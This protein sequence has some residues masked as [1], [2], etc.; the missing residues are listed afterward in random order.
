MPTPP[1]TPSRS[2][3]P[4]LN[5]FG[6]ASGFVE[7]RS[8][9]VALD[10]DPIMPPPYDKADLAAFKAMHE[11]RAE[12]YQQRLVLE[13]IIQACGTYENPFRP[14]ADGSRSSDFAAGKQFIGQQVVKLLNMP[15]ANDE[16]GEQG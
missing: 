13:W 8:L 16:Q 5:R 3:R 2:R 6:K 12:P 11:G 4:W 9:N 14:G 15:I 10:A 1:S 7:E